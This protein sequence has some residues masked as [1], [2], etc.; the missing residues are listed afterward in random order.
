MRATCKLDVYETIHQCECDI[1]NKKK[2]FE[3]TLKKLTPMGKLKWFWTPF[4]SLY[5]TTNR[6]VTLK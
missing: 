2:Q 5:I 6:Q 3:F 1:L 4:V